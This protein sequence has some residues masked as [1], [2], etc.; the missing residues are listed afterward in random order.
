MKHAKFWTL[1]VYQN[2]RKFELDILKISVAC[3]GFN[4][5]TKVNSEKFRVLNRKGSV[6]RQSQNFS[7]EK[8]WLT[9]G[10][11]WRELGKPARFA[12]S[13]L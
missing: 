12:Q 8:V 10:T 3:L 4:F 1:P 11:V 9:S 6:S 13:L 5:T 7:I 2:R